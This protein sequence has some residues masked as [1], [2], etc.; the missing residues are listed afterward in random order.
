[1]PTKDYLSDMTDRYA[2]QVARR[3]PRRM[4]GDVEK[5]LRSL[6]SDMLEERCQGL[7]PQEKDLDV[8]F[9]E[10]GSPAQFAAKYN[11]GEQSLIGPKYFPKYLM[12]LKIV[13]GA[14]FLGISLAS[15]VQALLPEAQPWYLA[16]L[17]WLAALFCSLL[18]AFAGVTILFAIFEKKGVRLSQFEDSWR[19]KDLP[20]VPAKKARIKRG[21][22]IA[23]IIFSIVFFVLFCLFPEVM[24]FYAN[25]Q[26]VPLFQA[27]ILHGMLFL[28]AI[29]LALGI[30][31]SCFELAEGRYTVRLAVF[32]TIVDGVSAILAIII[33]TRPVW[34]PEFWPRV[35]SITGAQGDTAF[36]EA[37]FSHFDL[38]FL[39]VL[40]FALILDA[41]V[42]WYRA[43]R[44][45]ES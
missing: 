42:H 11:G 38:L 23:D 32:S 20:P 10:L 2:Y 1:M 16:L 4:R 8:V 41:A 45:R 29:F 34:N 6:I 30:A 33:F 44:Y 27:E 17:H 21:D 12:L 39:G 7:P 26:A 9:A 25:G 43:L 3:L 13:L 19:A 35:F 22:C 37:F 14:V 36:L 15:V 40:L 18:C 31:N 24:V 5:E 28:F